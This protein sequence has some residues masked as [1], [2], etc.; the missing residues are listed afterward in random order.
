[1]TN[2]PGVDFDALKSTMTFSTGGGWKPK[3]GPNQ[4]RV[5]PPSKDFVAAHLGGGGQALSRMDL[6]F[7][8]H[9]VRLEGADTQVF[10][11]PRDFNQTCPACQFHFKHKDSTD[12]A[13]KAMADELNNSLRFALNILDMKDPGKGIQVFETGPMVRKQILN[14]VSQAIYGNCLDPAEGGRDFI[15]T[16][17]PKGEQGNRFRSYTTT[18]GPNPYSVLDQLPEGW[19]N[20]LDNLDSALPETWDLS[21]IE[22]LVAQAGI[23]VGVT[24]AGGTLPQAAAPAPAPPAP[25][26]APAPAAPASAPA[27]EQTTAPAPAHA[28]EQAAPAPAPVAP[29]GDNADEVRQQLDN[30]FGGG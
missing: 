10:R 6:A 11:C 22:G 19:V 15:V 18:P 2:V 27:V 29:E 20:L 16:M 14:I 28:A 23:Q 25:G 5:L 3:P 26:P 1:M 12:P 7:R 8:S 9:F 30:L 4:I 21:R 17:V 13:V 24:Q